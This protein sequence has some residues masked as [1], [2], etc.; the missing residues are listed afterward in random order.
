M[1]KIG[2]EVNVQPAE[3]ELSPAQI[4]KKVFIDV[5]HDGK[6]ILSF[7]AAGATLVFDPMKMPVVNDTIVRKL[8]TENRMRF[9]VAKEIAGE[10]KQRKPADDVVL[11]LVTSDGFDMPET[12]GQ[13]KQRLY[14]EGKMP[15][16]EYRWIRPEDVDTFQARGWE[17]DNTGTLKTFRGSGRGPRTIRSQ[18]KVELV[19]VRMHES[20]HK[21]LRAEKAEKRA[22]AL[23]VPEQNAR[24]QIRRL[25]AKVVEDGDGTGFAPISQG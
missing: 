1:S 4:G 3:V 17:V 21:K 11:G 9:N 12:A 23:R 7:D 13:A 22:R 16:Y 5:A 10:L 20:A 24:E 19:V 15:G 14:I 18:G 25:G 6:E 2:V 8:S